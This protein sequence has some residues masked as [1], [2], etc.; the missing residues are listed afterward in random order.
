[1][2]VTIESKSKGNSLVSRGGERTG[3]DLASGAVAVVAPGAVLRQRGA[4]PRRVLFET[5]SALLKKITSLKV[6]N[7]HNG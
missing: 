3:T 6:L 4:L 1:M 5:G 2:K 7:D